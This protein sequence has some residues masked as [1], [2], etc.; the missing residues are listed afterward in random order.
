M[1]RALLVGLSLVATLAIAQTVTDQYKVTLQPQYLKADM[2]M[3]QRLHVQKAVRFDGG[4][5]GAHTAVGTGSWD[6][7]VL[8]SAA[9]ETPCRE[10][11]AFPVGGALIGDGCEAASNLGAD[12]GLRLLSTAA[13]TCEAVAAGAVIK[14]CVS[15]TD[16]GTY[17]LHDA[18]FTV[19]TYR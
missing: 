8:G 15:L 10:S 19:R 2:V 4:T 16:G 6:F 9:G 14:L 17:D 7:A 5:I 12:G 11:G 18:G 3:G 1:K 13:L